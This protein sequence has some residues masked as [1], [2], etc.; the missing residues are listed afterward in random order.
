MIKISDLPFL[1]KLKKMDHILL[2]NE[3]LRLDVDKDK[4][5]REL[6]R[7]GVVCALGPPMSLPTSDS[8]VV[9]HKN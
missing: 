9:P 2:A 8:F 6:D 4:M 1:D 5:F 7:A 3:V